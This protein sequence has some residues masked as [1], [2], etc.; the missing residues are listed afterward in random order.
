[1]HRKSEQVR[2]V[3]AEGVSGRFVKKCNCFLEDSTVQERIKSKFAPG[4]AANVSRS[5]YFYYEVSPNDKPGM[6]IVCGGYELCARDYE[7][8]RGSYPYYVV[9]YIVRG[10]GAIEIRNTTH[11]LYSGVIAAF[12]PDDKHHYTCNPD[13]PL[14]HIFFALTGDMVPELF[15][16]CGLDKLG[17]IQSHDPQQSFETFM[18][19]MEIGLKKPPL[20]QELCCS[21]L[22]CVLLEQASENSSSREYESPSFKSFCRSKAYI[23]ENFSNLRGLRDAADAVGLNVRYISRLFKRYINLTPHGYLMRLK[24]NRAGTLL[25]ST[26]LPVGKIAALVGF[27]D[28]YHFSRNFRKH[29]GLSPAKYRIEH[30]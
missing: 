29:H 17:S 20:S 5:E 19:I 15:R 22:R 11:E 16:Q 4:D 27:D 7:V 30:S 12:S 25:L 10:K 18:K 8:Q 24:L 6:A 2:R 23:D 3:Q 26:D 1:M 9:E 28:Q 21:Y 14:E 13:D